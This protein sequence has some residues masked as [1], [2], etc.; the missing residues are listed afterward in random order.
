MQKVEI[1]RSKNIK[2]DNPRKIQSS[3]VFEIV[4]RVEGRG[5]FTPLPSSS[6]PDNQMKASPDKCHHSYKKREDSLE[7]RS[8]PVV[9]RSVENQ[10]IPEPIFLYRASKYKQTKR[11]GC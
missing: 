11:A 1:K 3:V 9:L 5:D 2:Q 8:E 10:A 6:Q 7:T 4:I